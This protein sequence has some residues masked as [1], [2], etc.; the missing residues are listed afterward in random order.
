MTELPPEVPPV[1]A[2]G[3]R[4]RSLPAQMTSLVGRQQEIAALKALLSRP[5][6]RLLTLTGPSGTGKTRLA[7]AVAETIAHAFADG[8]AFVPLA[9]I[10]EPALVCSAIA[11]ALAV[12]EPA[13][14]P[15]A[16][17]VTDYLRD[18]ELLLLLDNFEHLAA[19]APLV[20]ELLAACPRLKALVTSRAVLHLY[21]EHNVPVP[22]LRLP[23]SPASPEEADLL[24]L[25]RASEAVELFVARAT[26]ARPDF[27][28][29]AE[30]AGVLIQICRRLDGLPLAME[31]AAARIRLLPPAA[32]L[33]R[34]E[35]RLDLLRGGARDLPARQQTLRGAIGWSYDLL[36][37]SEQRLFRRLT[38]FVGGCTL[39]AAESVCS[40]GVTSPPDALE[41]I[42]A[43]LDQSLLQQ[44]EPSGGEPR[45]RILETVREYGLEQLLASGEMAAVQRR[46]AGY[47]LALAEEMDAQWRGPAPHVWFERLEQ[48]RDNLRAALAWSLTEGGDKEMGLR[49]GAALW[50]FWEIR[51]HLR[52]GREWLAR[53]L[54]LPEA[55]SY[56]AARAKALTAAGYLAT[57]QG[58]IAAAYPLLEA[59]LALARASGGTAN[60]TESLN[61]FGF[62]ALAAG[63]YERAARLLEESLACGRESGDETACHVALFNL[64]RVAQ[65]LGDYG[66][67][68]ALHEQSLALK[69]KQGESWS[70]ALSLSNLGH[71]AQLRGR[72]R[73]AVALF[74]ESLALR[75]RLGDRPGCCSPSLAWPGSPPRSAKRRARRGCWARPRRS[76]PRSAS[77]CRRPTASPSA[78]RRSRLPGPKGNGCRSSRQSPARSQS[79][80]EETS[81]RRPHHPRRRC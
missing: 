16:E 11:R 31:L 73:Q 25:A 7:L 64:A 23:V 19:A 29:T 65:A 78:N 28:L 32:L 40:S 74:Q 8:P 61:T 2:A 59:S 48:E 46:Y 57:I 49:L 13:R 12:H 22:P 10:Q 53:L 54:A 67:A 63:E 66:R 60:L 21:G 72:P 50:R 56:A 14:R 69:R 39:A 30:N 33:E 20:A 47:F 9:P 1:T 34:L 36:D 18:R 43:L 41:G 3:P 76:G 5:D 70:I 52:E 62:A 44:D 71:L 17:Q 4:R 51:G 26:A 15:L 79:P 42:A 38:V 45:L 81:R 27:A 24:A 58:D 6:V 55:P 37:W 68:A 75:Q 35:R 80:A 77:P